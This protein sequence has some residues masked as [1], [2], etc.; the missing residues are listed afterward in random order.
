MLFARVITLVAGANTRL[1]HAPKLQA[2]EGVLVTHVVNRSPES[3][4]KAAAELGIPHTLPSWQE[5]VASTEVDA[6]CIGTWPY[7]HAEMT[8]AA[9]G[10]GKHVLCE[11]RMAMNASEAVQMLAAARKAKAERGLTAQIVPSPFTLRFDTTIRNIIQSGVLGKLLVINV[12]GVGSTFVDRDAEMHWRQDKRLSGNNI[13]MMGIFYEAL[14]RWVGEATSV[15]AMG[16]I[17]VGERG[18]ELVQVPEH[19]GVMAKME[20]GAQAQMEFSTLTGN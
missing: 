2:I 6:I 8:I 16:K 11:A 18:G 19:L 5:L 13:L 12:R 3:S 17:E 4:A 9:L 7:T 14:M 10:H 1:H 15:M 20:C